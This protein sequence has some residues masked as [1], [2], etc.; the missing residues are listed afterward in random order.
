MRL[1]GRT[2][3]HVRSFRDVVKLKQCDCSLHVLQNPTIYFQPG[4]FQLQFITCFL[5]DKINANI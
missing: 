3:A 4:V 1:A 2:G 5:G